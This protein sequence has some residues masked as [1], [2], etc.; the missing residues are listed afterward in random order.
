[1]ITLPALIR[2]AVNRIRY[3]DRTPP[4]A[5]HVLA[6][7]PPW[8]NGDTHPG[9]SG[10]WEIQPIRRWKAGR[11]VSFQAGLTGPEEAPVAA[12][13]AFAEAAFSEPVT[14][15]ATCAEVI[16]HDNRTGQGHGSWHLFRAYYL[17][18]AGGTC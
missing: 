3:R 16:D 12:L 13:A 10:W 7:T 4:G 2:D 5:T 15:G 14:L 18:P 1:M 6:W 11:R 8:L 17:S 9:K